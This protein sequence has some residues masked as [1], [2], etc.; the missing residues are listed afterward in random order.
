M[1][2]MNPFW[3][4]VPE[5][6]AIIRLGWS[7]RVRTS[8][9]RRALR[10]AASLDVIA[11]APLLTALPVHVVISFRV[12]SHVG[13]SYWLF[14]GA[15]FALALIGA[16]SATLEARR[17]RRRALHAA[18][19]AVGLPLCK[20]CCYDLR[21]VPVGIPCPECNTPYP[22]PPE[23]VAPYKPAASILASTRDDT[24]VT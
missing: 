17:T 5:W 2:S 1:G 7:D 8:V 16:L 10:W 18:A 22:N 23:G 21:G 3:R 11:I 14:S 15:S 24:S 13:S 12:R 20:K 6:W 19:Y 9:G 4:L